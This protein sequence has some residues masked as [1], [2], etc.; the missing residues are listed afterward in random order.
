MIEFCCGEQSKIGQPSAAN[1][2]CKVI[3]VA[4]SVD[5]RGNNVDRL[6]DLNDHVGPILLFASMPCAGGSPWYYMNKLAPG[7]LVKYQAHIKLFDQLWLKFED[8]CEK[9]NGK[10]WAYCY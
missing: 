2:G 4:E 5:A 3:R 9:V 6:L 1:V 10:L 8:L 7:G